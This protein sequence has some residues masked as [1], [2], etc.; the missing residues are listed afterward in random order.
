[1]P[2][3]SERRDQPRGANDARASLQDAVALQGGA[4]SDL[5]RL[6]RRILG[7]SVGHLLFAAV[8]TAYIFVGIFLEE[9]D[10]IRLFGEEYKR[11]RAQVGMLIPFRRKL[12]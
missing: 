10:L 9:R 8:T 11:Y 12:S 1:M 4:A 2:C 7:G 3:S 5:S 6:H